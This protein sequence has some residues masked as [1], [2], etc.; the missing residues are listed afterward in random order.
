[1]TQSEPSV[2]PLG[3]LA[4]GFATLSAMLAVTYF[5]SVFA[6]PA[7]ALAIPLGVMARAHER[8]RTVGTTAVV[9][10]V[11]AVVGATVVLFSS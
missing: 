2:R 3:G 10:A 6:Y 4:L 9:V 8:S 7:A 5:F 1:M 11:I